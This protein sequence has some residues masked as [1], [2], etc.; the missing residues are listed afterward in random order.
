MFNTTIKSKL[1]LTSIIVVLAMMATLAVS[2][3]TIEQIKIKSPTYDAIIL[4]KDLIADILPP[5]EYII[6]TKLVTHLMMEASAQEIPALKEKLISLQKEYADR[7]A[8]WSKSALEPKARELILKTS[9]EPA[10]KFFKVMNEEFLAAIDA[11]DKQKASE[12]SIQKLKP[13]YEEHRKA[14]DELVILANKQAENDEKVATLALKKGAIFVTIIGVAGLGVAITLLL[15]LSKSIAGKLK[16]IENSIRELESGDGDLTKRLDIV[17]NDE[18]KAA[19]DLFDKFMIKTQII[20]AKA[21]NI[22]ADGASTAL[23]LRTTSYQIGSRIEEASQTVV[24]IS[25]EIQPIK[26]FADESAAKLERASDEIKNAH[27]TLNVAKKTII[28][29]LSKVRQNSESELELSSKLTKLNEEASQV[30]NILSAINDIADQ[31]NLLALNA[32]IEAARAG[33]HGRGF[34]VV[35]EEVRKLAE[36]TQKSLSETNA[37]ISVI[38]Q[39][40]SDLCDEMLSNTESVKKVL[41][42]SAQTEIEISNVSDAIVRS[43]ETSKEASHKASSISHQINKVAEEIQDI[44]NSSLQNARSIEEIAAAIDHLSGLNSTLLLTMQ[45]FKV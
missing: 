7:Q 18:I 24:K 32:A 30:K 12:I 4:S 20:V 35:A 6:E 14:V 43:I 44:E 10:E 13:L 15:L 31:T 37:T 33:E 2:F 19:G 25:H 42:E 5:P 27:E 45:G 26:Q 41:E 39:S 28:Q 34:A 9:K 17:G 8:Y 29:T 23:Q 3:F 11:K 22:A 21:Q 16:L 38:T 36:K 1:T 40:I